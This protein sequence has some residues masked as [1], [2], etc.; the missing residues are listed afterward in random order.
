MLNEIVG[1]TLIKEYF[2]HAFRHNCIA[3][4]YMISGE[5]DTGQELLSY[6]LAYALLC[7]SKEHQPCGICRSCKAAKNRNHPDLIVLDNK[8]KSSISVDEIREKIADTVSIKPFA[9][10]RKIYIILE[11]EKMTVQAQNSLL[12]T[13]EEPPKYAV[14]ILATAH[15]KNLLST[16]HSRCVRLE[17]ASIDEESLKASLR[18]KYDLNE[19]LLQFIVSVSFGKIEKAYYLAEN[20][21]LLAVYDK[22]PSLITEMEEGLFDSLKLKL[23]ELAKTGMELVQS[24]DLIKLWYRDILIYLSTGCTDDIF[25]NK[26]IEE[27]KKNATKYSFQSVLKIFVAIDEAN[28]KLRAKVGTDLVLEV[29]RQEVRFGLL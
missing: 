20:Q 3:S 28:T 4:S 16:I 7:D 11:A 26:Y 9:S 10:D 8:E 21:K 29:L 2:E 13:L 1:N 5:E 12:K 23:E 27:I 19:T 25:F 22:V 17:T 6:E 15:D 18:G 14:F 24:L